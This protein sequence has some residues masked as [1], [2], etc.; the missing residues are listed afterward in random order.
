MGQELALIHTFTMVS[1]AHSQR[2]SIVHSA[3]NH[4]VRVDNI[5]RVVGA[6]VMLT[7]ALFKQ[8]ATPRERLPL[9][10]VIV[11]DILHLRLKFMLLFLLLLAETNYLL[12]L[13]GFVVANVL[14]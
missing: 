11:P 5:H 3:I 2:A 4:F 8:S 7:A 12:L 1:V 14:V 9:K 10:V 13:Q 6:T